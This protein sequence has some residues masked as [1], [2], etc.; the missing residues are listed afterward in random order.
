MGRILVAAS[1]WI[2]AGS[3]WAQNLVQ[4]GSF[5]SGALAP[6]WLKVARAGHGSWLVSSGK[7][8][9]TDGSR[10]A[11]VQF[12]FVD[13]TVLYQDITLPEDG[14]YTVQLAAGCTLE[15]AK[16]PGDFCRVDVT[17][18]S[19]ETIMAPMPRTDTL[20]STTHG[21]IKPL[22]AADGGKGTVALKDTSPVRLEGKAGQV[23]R[24]RAM[25]LA[26][27]R[28]IAMTIDNVRL[29]REAK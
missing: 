26:S 6:N 19:D 10:Y 17:D 25:A 27:S 22:F 20:A 3:A 14:N 12:D 28:A 7:P 11:E 13:G 16:T 5:E 8:P 23:V 1:V 4:D 24:I 21:L 9:A 2:F 18:T 29:Q 15:G